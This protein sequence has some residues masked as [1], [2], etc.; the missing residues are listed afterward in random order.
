MAVQQRTALDFVFDEAGR[1]NCL[2]GTRLLDGEALDL[3]AS[4][5]ILY[6]RLAETQLR[7]SQS[8][9]LAEIEGSLETS[10]DGEL[11]RVEQFHHEVIGNLLAMAREQSYNK[12]YVTPVML[13]K[14]TVPGSSPVPLTEEVLAKMR[15]HTWAWKQDVL[16]R[17]EWAAERYARLR[18][19]S[20]I[21]P[22]LLDV[23]VHGFMGNPNQVNDSHAQ[24]VTE[25]YVLT[26]QLLDLL[27][28]PASEWTEET[29]AIQFADED[30]QAQYTAVIHELITLVTSADEDR[31]V[32]WSLFMDYRL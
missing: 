13:G 5:G 1:S 15:Q 29:Y 25:I 30:D 11:G 31:K 16:S 28:N 20:T 8:D 2:P 22:E 27:E 10:F 14:L 7:P 9:W 3:V 24:F 23:L 19:E 17:A 12:H 18:R 4:L 21:D 32:F 26:E 6:S